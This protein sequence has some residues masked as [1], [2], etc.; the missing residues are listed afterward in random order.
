MISCSGRFVRMI[1]I[2][3]TES[4]DPLSDQG[5]NNSHGLK[6]DLEERLCLQHPNPCILAILFYQCLVR[7]FLNDGRVV[8]ESRCLS[9]MYGQKYEPED[10]QYDI[11]VSR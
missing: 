5:T 8:H 6:S 11:R 2:A 3:R 4:R 1:N 10:S 7:S 9:L